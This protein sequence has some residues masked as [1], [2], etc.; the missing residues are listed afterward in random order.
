MK[1]QW[2][3]FKVDSLPVPDT[4]TPQTGSPP[5]PTKT[6]TPASSEAQL[7]SA[8]VEIKPEQNPPA[9]KPTTWLGRS[10]V[11]NACSTIYSK[12][13]LD[14]IAQGGIA[15]SVALGTYRIVSA[16]DDNNLYDLI[17]GI[18]LASAGTTLACLAWGVGSA[19]KGQKSKALK[20]FAATIGLAAATVQLIHTDQ[21]IDKTKSDL[22]HKDWKIRD[23]QREKDH[24][25]RTIDL[26]KYSGS[27]YGESYELSR[28]KTQLSEAQAREASTKDELARANDHI[29]SLQATPVCQKKLQHTADKLQKCTTTIEAFK[30][31]SWAERCVSTWPPT[32]LA[33][34]AAD[35]ETDGTSNNLKYNII[36]GSTYVGGNPLRDDLSKLVDKTHQEYAKRWGITHR[37]VDKSLLKNECYVGTKTQDCVPYWN[38][39]A[40]LRNWLNEPAKGSKQEWYIL[41]DDDMPATDMTINPSEAI[42][43]LRKGKD[44]SV[45]VARDVQVWNGDK[46]S[47]V[48]TGLLFVRKDE[49]S[50]QFI[51]EVWRKRNTP[52]SGKSQVCPTLGT[53]VN[54]ETLHEQE[55]MSYVIKQ[56]YS[57]L[58][59]VL[60]VV[61]P[62]DKY[63]DKDGKMKELAVNTFHRGGCFRRDQKHWGSE[64]F[65][66]DGDASYPE[67]AWRKGDW[68]GQT[69]GV[70]INGWYCADYRANKPAGPLR[71]DKLNEMISQTVR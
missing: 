58:D 51:E 20:C 42:D 64:T 59:R 45:I 27:S 62:R 25:Q 16:N 38:K 50:R 53:C 39:I 7:P 69:A 4:N 1:V 19:L 30:K 15:A 3:G 22:W 2:V 5:S 12:L 21:I 46:R 8:T 60:T 70:P 71:L 9:T 36:F 65:S 10:W 49:Q 56:D 44:T 29:A 31:L 40:V 37:V 23:L 54:Q 61:M 32:S 68:L 13:T 52:T 63:R 35:S 55:A 43:M 6:G 33:T 26:A 48:N 18:G 24:L 41:A 14:N 28:L 67:G 11:G 17:A 47:A 34:Q 57:L 66:Y